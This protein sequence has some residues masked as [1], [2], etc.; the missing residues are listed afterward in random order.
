MATITFD[1]LK[2]VRKL[3]E[4]GFEEKQA[5]GIADAFKD[6]SGEAELSTKRDLE[7]LK[8]DLRVDLDRIERKQIEHDGEFK[9][10]KW[11]LGVAVGGIV[12]LLMKSFFAA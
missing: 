12:A 8:M 1:T 10:L 4:V 5:E 11:M 2:F 3:R 7:L 9:L 6:A